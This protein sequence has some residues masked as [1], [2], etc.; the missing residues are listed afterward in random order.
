MPPRNTSKRI[1][2]NRVISEK[3]VE[4]NLTTELL[5]WLFG[6]TGRTHYVIAPSQQEE[7]RLGFDAGFYGSGPGLFI[8]FKRAHVKGSVWTWRLN[9]TAEED[10]HQRLQVLEGLGAPV[11]YAFPLFNESAHVVSWRRR[12][13]THTLWVRPS[14]LQ[15]PSGPTG[16]HDLSVDRLSGRWELSSPEPIAIDD[17]SSRLEELANVFSREWREDLFERLVAQSNLVLFGGE[18]AAGLQPGQFVPFVRDVTTG[19]GLV[20]VGSLSE[21]ESV[22]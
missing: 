4:L 13:L 2:Q 14:R 8:Q 18:G 19:D 12:L 5:N 10:Q 7:A 3:T 11:F 15:P 6:I 16:P 17:P 21:Q 22:H 9:R 20:I 1:T